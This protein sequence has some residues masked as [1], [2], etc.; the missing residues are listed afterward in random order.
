MSL[1]RSLK[2]VL[3][4]QAMNVLGIQLDPDEVL[5]QSETALRRK[6]RRN[7]NDSPNGGREQ[8]LPDGLDQVVEEN[9]SIADSGSVISTAPTTMSDRI[10]MAAQYAELLR[11][12]ETV[13]SDLVRMRID[14]T[15]IEI[16]MLAKAYKKERSEDNL[17]AYMAAKAA[18]YRL[19]KILKTVSAAEAL[20][21]GEVSDQP[22]PMIVDHPLSD[23]E[24]V[25]QGSSPRNYLPPHRRNKHRE[26]FDL[27]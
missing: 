5:A 24:P 16:R 20:I 6:N 18:H 1:D 26:F 8:G 15:I 9:E 10:G 14:E 22:D 27:F 23:T 2:M 3:T 12:N 17:N 13:S 21:G 7:T 11:N 19:T 25:D 4:R